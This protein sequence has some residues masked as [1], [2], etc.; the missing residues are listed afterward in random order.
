M[1]ALFYTINYHV[2]VPK[3]QHNNLLKILLIQSTCFLFVIYSIS[4][5]YHLF[6]AFSTQALLI[7]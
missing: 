4:I 5:Q 1:R 7:L 2:H 6:H 3:M